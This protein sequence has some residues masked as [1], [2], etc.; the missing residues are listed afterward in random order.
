MIYTPLTKKAMRVAYDA[1]SGQVDKTGLPY[2]YHPIAVAM[3][4][5]TEDEFCAAILHDV[6]EDSD[7]TIDDLRAA[8]FPESVVEAVG[9]V[10]DDNSIKSDESY[11][12]YLMAIKQN[13]L[14][15]KVKLADLMHN[16]NRSRVDENQIDETMLIRWDRYHNAIKLLQT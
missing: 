2:I 5:D 6:I 10:T 8:G 13:P 16:S 12:A 11:I 3:Q 1:H 4:M 7:M 15:T 9:L 14:A